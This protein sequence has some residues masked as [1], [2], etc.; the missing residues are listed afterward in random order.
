MRDDK[1]YLSHMLD[2]IGTIETY[3]AGKTFAEFQENKMMLDAVVRELEIIGEAANRISEELKE[4]HPH[5]P[6]F[7]I[8]GLRNFVIH[9]YFAVN[10]KIVWDTCK[11]NLPILK[12]Q[13]EELTL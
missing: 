13:L 3:I 9:E 7:K 11:E 2:A 5:V 1:T 8:R 10:E 6:W 4:K 12:Q